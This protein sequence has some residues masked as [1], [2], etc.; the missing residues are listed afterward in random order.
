MFSSDILEYQNAIVFSMIKRFLE[1]IG[2]KE[3]L[4]LRIVKYALF[5][6]MEIWWVAA[7]ENIGVEINGKGNTFA[8]PVLVYKKLNKEIFL[9]IP[10]STQIKEGSW[11]VSFDF[12]DRLICTNLAQVRIMSA[13]RLYEKMGEVNENDFAKV[14]SGFLRLYS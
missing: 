6:E 4:E 14:K 13:G 1:W 8:R 7:G 5:R 2:V 10:L 9:A 11:Y 12:K 3:K